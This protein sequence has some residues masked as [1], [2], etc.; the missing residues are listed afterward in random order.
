MR[1]LFISAIAV[2]SFS[3]DAIAQTTTVYEYDA[4]GRLVKATAGSAPATRY[5]YDAT[6]N[7]T[8]VTNNPNL[9]PVAV[10][11]SFFRVGGVNNNP[12]S[13]VW[14]VRNNDTDPNLPND[15]L[16][17]ISVT[18]GAGN[19]NVSVSSGGAGVAYTATAGLYFFN[20]TIQD[21]QGETSSVTSQF[22]ISCRVGAPC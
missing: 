1:W 16:T 10:A 12:V 21:S 4:L 13:G 5:T 22:E 6:D 2:A 20:Y 18:P 19:P 9:P 15:T 17:V 3:Q 14:S 7:R 8:K 11:D